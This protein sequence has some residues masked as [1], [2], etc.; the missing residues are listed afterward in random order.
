[1]KKRTDL[2]ERVLEVGLDENL[3]KN[4]AEVFKK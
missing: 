2:E 1:M 4:L 3:V